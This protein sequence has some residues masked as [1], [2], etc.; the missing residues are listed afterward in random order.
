MNDLTCRIY[1]KPTQTMHECKFN[2]LT[3]WNNG[4]VYFVKD[5]VSITVNDG[6]DRELIDIQLY[7]GKKDKIGVKI[8]EDDLVQV[9]DNKDDVYRVDYIPEFM[10]F[11]F[12]D[13]VSCRFYTI[14]DLSDKFDTFNVESNLKVVGNIWQI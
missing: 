2:D 11:A 10:T 14:D 12:V 6:R 8:F 3:G 5:G 13:R 4:G 9:G 1:H 7:T